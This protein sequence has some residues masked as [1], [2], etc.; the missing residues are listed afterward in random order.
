MLL[1]LD[2]GTPNL[3][4]RYRDA[5]TKAERAFQP[6]SIEALELNMLACVHENE[7]VCPHLSSPLRR[8]RLCSRQ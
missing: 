1:S 7:F 2:F 4:I 3:V 5:T 6:D 8:E